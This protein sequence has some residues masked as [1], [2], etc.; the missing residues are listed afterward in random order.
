MDLD[1]NTALPYITAASLAVNGLYAWTSF[2]RREIF[3][4]VKKARAFYKDPDKTED[5]FWEVM[6]SLD[7]VM[8]KK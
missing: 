8:S 6:D 1:I 7:A 4:L 2:R 5:E 3:S